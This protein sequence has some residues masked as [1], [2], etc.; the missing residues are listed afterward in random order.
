MDLP[1]TLRR[2]QHGQFSLRIPSRTEET[3]LLNPP[4]I[5]SQQQ[6]QQQQPQQQQQSINLTR[7]EIH[8]E[9]LEE[10]IHL[11]ANEVKRNQRQTRL[12]FE[13]IIQLLLFLI[14]IL[15][16]IIGVGIA[17]LYYDIEDGRK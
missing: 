12:E 7:I 6:Q 2:D 13:R 14:V 10:E 8:I 1:I 16:A 17:S 11:F 15:F 4:L 5:G 9:Q 3:N